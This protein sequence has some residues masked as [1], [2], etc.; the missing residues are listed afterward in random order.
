MKRTAVWVIVIGAAV[1]A[2]S[3]VWV[4]V[5]PHKPAFITIDYP[6]GG[7]IF[8]PDFTAPTFLWRDP[9][10]KA[11]MWSIRVSF[12]DQSEDVRVMSGGERMQVGEIDPRCVA[13]TNEIPRLTPAQ[14]SAHTWKP[15]LA[16]WEM[17]K[18]RSRAGPATI[19][20]A[21]LRDRDSTEPVSR[22]SLTIRTSSDPVGA[23]IFYRDVP[24]IPSETQKGVIKPLAQGALPLIA[25]RL[26]DVSQPVSRTMM[27]GLPTCA[28][29][30]SVSRDGKTLGM[31][32]DGPLNDKGLYAVVPIRP[33]TSIRNED[34][35]T[36]RNVYK[37]QL[38]GKLRVGFMS[39]VSPDGQYVMTMIADPGVSQTDS[40]RR[41][42]PEDLISTYYVNN[43]K[44]Y[45]FG[46]VFYPTRGILAWYSRATGRMLPLPGADDPHYVH[47][48]PTWSP[49]GQFIVFARAEAREAYP[50]GGKMA[51]YA[52]DPNETQIKYDLYRIPFNGGKGGK[53]EP[54]QGASQNGMS[55]N[56]P[57]ISPDGRWIVFVKCR[58]GQLMRP[59]SELYIVPAAGG[60]PRRMRC[61]TPLM[62]SWHSFSPNG[63][64]LVF[65]SKGRSPYT[66]MYLT[67]LD[68]QGQ[69]SPA[70]L[71][72]DATKANRAVNIP[73]F[74][75]VPP[76]GLLKM[77]APATEFYRL[78]EVA[79]TL[80]EKGEYQ[81]AVSELQKAL[82]INPDD[83]RARSKLGVALAR[84]GRFDEAVSECRKAAELDPA[85]AD[86]H[87][88]LGIA[89]AQKGKPNEAIPQFE[90]S[91]QLSPDNTEAHANLAAALMSEGRID[92]AI[93]HCRKALSVNPEYTLAH[94]NL[95]I[96]LT[97]SR[98]LDEAMPH[99][100]KALAAN[101]D[102]VEL[103]YILGRALAEKN[104]VDEAIPHLEKVLAANP[105]STELHYNLA[106]L[107]VA[108]RRFE[109]AIPH[110]EIILRIAPGYRQA[111]YDLGN[112][113]Y[114]VPGRMADAMAI[115]SELLRQQPDNPIV[116]NRIAR[117]RATS[118]DASFRNGP[119]AVRLAQRAVQLTRS[120]EPTF[121]DTLS[122]AYAE[123][124]RFPDAIQT[125]REARD[126]AA[127]K[128]NA[129]LATALSS[130]IALYQG[131]KPFRE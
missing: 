46:Q 86:A 14:A 69:D 126:L 122:A 114:F 76:D 103:H 116:L 84:T 47:T 74:V 54:V 121:I 18:E 51:A 1:A 35:I 67:H 16:T 40:Q 79:T 95:A 9:S 80:A 85:Y 33:H 107:L 60:Q 28:N 59:D 131:Q 57:K 105:G 6:E 58:N 49:D 29:C 130:R 50:P 65:S 88:N 64:W 45:R 24:L 97:R 52:N 90:K 83:A 117:V 75:N 26:R 111:R 125:A 56:F 129:A 2:A 4:R 23:P 94:A 7:T 55:N 104:R 38:R 91:L 68:E 96:A 12:A 108:A 37:G 43:F 20:I 106:H 63:R 30:H 98:K 27:E 34:V 13:E 78:F 124:G 118:F 62:N 53:A 61:N 102:S 100:E 32:V 119:E 101:P 123:S 25:W 39:Q 22:G 92:E 73:E 66:Q 120:Q 71:V 15:D 112:A 48:D 110:F 72:E 82:K 70:I 109:Q 93:A 17:I 128:N 113:L 77:D 87:M 42:R 41:A 10:E 3:L 99:F 89:L 81:A 11:K 31:D 36:W 5:A 115:W 8:P 127:K 21:G 44:D 19:T